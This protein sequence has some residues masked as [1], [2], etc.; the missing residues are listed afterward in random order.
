MLQVIDHVALGRRDQPRQRGHGMP[1]SPQ[2]RGNGIPG[3]AIGR[4]GSVGHGAVIYA[5]NPAVS[6]E[7]R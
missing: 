2:M 3:G 1:V 6:S 5:I 7:K 4:L